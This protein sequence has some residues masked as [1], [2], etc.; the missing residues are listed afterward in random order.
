MAELV[1]QERDE[2][3]QRRRAEMDTRRTKAIEMAVE[4]YEALVTD[5]DVGGKIWASVL[6]EAIKRRNP[7]FNETYFGFRSFG[8]LLEEAANRGLLGF[9]RDEKSGA[10]VTRVT[11]LPAAVDATAV[12]DGTGV[13]L[14]Y[15]PGIGVPIRHLSHDVFVQSEALLWSLYDQVTCPTLL[16]R[17]AD[18]DVLTPATAQ[19]MSERGPRAQCLT[20]PQVGHAPTLVASEQ[21]TPVVNWLLA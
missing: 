11:S 16:L 19:A 18:S 8:N 5:R 21:A 7:G 4:T 9:G 3:E 20:F 17:G 15:D 6:K 14:H 1:E 2:E 13:R 10:Y 12:A